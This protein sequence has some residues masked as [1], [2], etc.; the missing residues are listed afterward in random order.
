VKF[1]LVLLLSPFTPIIRGLVLVKLW[2]W[3]IVGWFHVPEIS[4]PM[5]LGISLIVGFL[6]YQDPP[7][8]GKKNKAGVDVGHL[9]MRV[10]INLCQSLFALGLGAVYRMFL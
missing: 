8:S 1:V 6:T 3:F 5:A 10:L 2:K 4:I 9:F 7:D